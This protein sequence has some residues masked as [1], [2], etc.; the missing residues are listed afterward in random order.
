VQLPKTT[1][2]R[3]ICVK[4]LPKLPREKVDDFRHIDDHDFIILRRKL[5]RWAADNLA[6]LKEAR[7][8]MPQGFNNRLRMNW[9]LPFAIADLAGGDWPNLAR[10]AAIKLTHERREQSEGKRLLAA[11]RDLFSAHGSVLASAEVQRLLNADLSNEWG[12]F[13]SG[14]RPISQ[15]EIALLLDAYDI[16][17]TYIHR[18]RKTERGYRVAHFAEAFRHY[19]HEFPIRKRATVR[20]EQD[21]H[22]NR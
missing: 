2:T 1:A 3:T 13:R 9:E 7:P 10:R 17:P 21:W 20:K 5:A 12:D 14:G 18:S 6:A 22:R 4:L 11:F 19:L 15:R 8:A 16:H